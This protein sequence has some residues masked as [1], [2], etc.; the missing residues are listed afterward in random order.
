MLKDQTLSPCLGFRF[1]WGLS[2]VKTGTG[3][4]HIKS[5]QNKKERKKE[6][7]GKQNRVTKVMIYFESQYL[8][9][10]LFQPTHASMYLFSSI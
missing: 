6:R 1:S 5:K 3:H 10:E 7:K 8:R 9:S 4:F 2:E